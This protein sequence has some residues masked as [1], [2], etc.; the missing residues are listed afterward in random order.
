MRRRCIVLDTLKSE[1]LPCLT[2]AEPPYAQLAR[3]T[4]R[5]AGS[6]ICHKKIK[7]SLPAGLPL[8][9]YSNYDNEIKVGN[10]IVVPRNHLVI[11]TPSPTMNNTECKVGKHS[12]RYGGG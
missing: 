10:S 5:N 8:F 12:L 3:S 1:H 4:E 11:S 6:L 7:F 9:L 2:Q